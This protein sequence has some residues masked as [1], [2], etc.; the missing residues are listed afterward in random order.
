M[1]RILFANFVRFIVLVF[2]QAFLLKN[3]T[4]YE[5]STPYLYILFVMLLPFETPNIVLFPLAFLIGLCVDAFY[6]TP[7]LHAASTVLLA[8]VRVLFVNVT[9]QKEGL[10][11]DPQPT[12]AS[13]GFRW[14]FTYALILTLFHHFL[15]FN[16]EVFSWNEIQYTLS[17]FLLSTVFTVFLIIISGLLFFR[18]KKA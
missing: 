12:L 11:T 14:F 15:L 7:G 1:S 13:M 2:I 4:V 5:L 16:L 10:D 8:F 17:R 6:D 18:R 3:M 9:V